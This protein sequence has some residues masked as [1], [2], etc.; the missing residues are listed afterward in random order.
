MKVTQS[1]TNEH[2]L[3]LI[4]AEHEALVNL[5]TEM[6]ATRRSGGRRLISA[7]KLSGA[8]AIARIIESHIVAFHLHDNSRLVPVQSHEM[9]NAVVAPMLYLL[10]SQPRFAGAERAYQNALRELRDRDAA[11]AA[12]ALREVIT[13]LGCD[14]G[15]L[16]DLVSSAK[17]T[18][19]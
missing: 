19:F 12:T 9:H 4:E 5:V 14:G 3:S 8:S 18:G 17:K 11:D 15:A 6:S 10:H 2:L 7:R 1:S 13:A 16:D